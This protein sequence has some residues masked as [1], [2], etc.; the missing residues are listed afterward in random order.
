MQISNKIVHYLQIH[1]AVILFGFTAIL[2]ELIHLP[3]IVLVWWR[4]LLTVF[5]LL[6]FIKF[7][8][9]LKQ[10]PKS[11]MIRYAGIGVI[12]GLHWICF[13]GS[14]KLSNASICLI[15]LSTTAFFTSIIEPII[16]KRKIDKKEMFIGSLM[17]PGMVLIVNNVDIGYLNGIIVGL[18]SALFASIFTVLNKVYIKEADPY[19]ISF[20]ELSGAWVLVSVV[21]LVMTLSGIHLSSYI[22]ATSIEWVWLLI[23]AFFCTTLAQVLSLKALKHLS[24]FTVNLVVNLEPIYGIILAVIILHEHNVLNGMFYVG[25]SIIALSVF[26]YPVISKF[27]SKKIS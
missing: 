7:G 2:G 27:Q 15:C 23:F 9:E 8:R 20:I 11:L 22:P 3:A 14:L 1:I 21:L 10:L 4:V 26:L 16:I 18:L 12:I 6:F 17:I 13:Y 19:T 5:S 25:A 24:T